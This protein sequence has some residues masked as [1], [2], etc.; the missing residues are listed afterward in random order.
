MIDTRA[1]VTRGT[2]KQSKHSQGDA[3]RSETRG[4]QTV[5][6]TYRFQPNTEVAGQISV[7]RPFIDRYKTCQAIFALL[8]PRS[9]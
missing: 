7:P 9:H 1:V 8:S 2:T 5:G 3:N 4:P 6:Y